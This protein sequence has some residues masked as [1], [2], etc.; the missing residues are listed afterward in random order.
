MY[1]TIK[2]SKVYHLIEADYYMTPYSLCG[3]LSL[4]SVN[5]FEHL[6]HKKRLCKLCE[7]KQER[8]RYL[9]TIPTSE[10][11]TKITEAYLKN[12]YPSKHGVVLPVG[13]YRTTRNEFAYVYTLQTTRV[14][15]YILDNE[16]LFIHRLPVMVDFKSNKRNIPLHYYLMDLQINQTQKNTLTLSNLARVGALGPSLHACRNSSLR[17]FDLNMVAGLIYDRGLY[18][19]DKLLGESNE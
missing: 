1:A 5:V 13:R 7:A 19:L 6:P 11:V 4:R 3:Q 2:E 18:T 17:C 8:K 15:Y 9:K 16:E 14:D 12:A 10:L